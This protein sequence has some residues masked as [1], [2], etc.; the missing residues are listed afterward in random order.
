MTEYTE[1]LRHSLWR[2]PQHFAQ[3]QISI[4]PKY[5]YVS[6]NIFKIIILYENDIDMLGRRNRLFLCRFPQEVWDFWD[7]S[8]L[9]SILLK[10]WV[11]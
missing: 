1:K 4:Q 2:F 9:F 7:V 6:Y 3:T 10:T 5:S 11:Q 8:K